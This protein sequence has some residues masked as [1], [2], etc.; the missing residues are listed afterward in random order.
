MG[1]GWVWMGMGWGLMGMRWGWM[2]MGWI[3]GSRGGQYRWRR[4][5]SHNTAVGAAPVCFAAAD[6]VEVRLDEWLMNGQMRAGLLR[7][8]ARPLCVESA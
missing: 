6:C 1:M 2:G 7:W 5:F 8:Q 4:G 3:R